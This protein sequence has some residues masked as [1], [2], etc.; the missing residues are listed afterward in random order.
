MVSGSVRQLSLTCLQS[1]EILT[2]YSGHFD[3][4]MWPCRVAEIG[5]NQSL[6]TMPECCLE[7]QTVKKQKMQ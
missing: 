2:I 4:L 3:D 6:N 1:S 7:R 5:D